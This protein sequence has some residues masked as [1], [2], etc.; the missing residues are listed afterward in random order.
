MLLLVLLQCNGAVVLEIL[1][2]VASVTVI[3]VEVSFAG[4]NS[5]GE[6][7]CTSPITGLRLFIIIP[8]FSSCACSEF[9][10]RRR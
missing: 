4:G 2:S 3:P 8:L 1:V 7:P 9:L 10:T 6:L 5:P